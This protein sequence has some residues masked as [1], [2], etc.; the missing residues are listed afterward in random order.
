[1]TNK[2]AMKYRMPETHLLMVWSGQLNEQTQQIISEAQRFVEARP[3]VAEDMVELSRKIHDFLPCVERKQWRWEHDHG[4]CPL[5][6][7][8]LNKFYNQ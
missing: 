4:V 5:C 8:N 7:G 3:L 1:M 6:D 2:M